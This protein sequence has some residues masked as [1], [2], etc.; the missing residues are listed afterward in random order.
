M[1]ERIMK[2]LWKMRIEVTSMFKGS[3]WGVGR[4]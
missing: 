2:D 1:I 3:I 4:I